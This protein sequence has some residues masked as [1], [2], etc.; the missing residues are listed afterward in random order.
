MLTE[1]RNKEPQTTPANPEAEISNEESSTEERGKGTWREAFLSAFQT[2]RWQQK[3]AGSRQELGRDKS[4]S[5]F[6][7]VGVC[8]ALLLLFL[9]MFSR[10]KQKL[11]LPGENPR[12]EASLGRKVTPG[13]E[14][15]DPT[16]S[17]TP[18]LSANV[19]SP[20]PALA[21]QL[22]PEDIGRTSRTGMAPRP[23]ATATKTNSPQD[24]ALSKVDFSDPSVGQGTVRRMDARQMHAAVDSGCDENVHQRCELPNYGR[25]SVA[26]EVI[27]LWRH[28]GDGRALRTRAPLAIERR[29]THSGLS[30][31]RE[32]SQ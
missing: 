12:G 6:L 22:T 18:M 5:L 24:Y 7:V 28:S 32:E 26:T 17:A 23:T 11:S 21:G 16:K 14:N 19:R 9:G 25:V 27:A 15:S 1:E 4:K 31:G 13:Q 20:D 10:P 8:V 30:V 29:T 3:P 2:A